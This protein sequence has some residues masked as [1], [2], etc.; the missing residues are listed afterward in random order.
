MKKKKYLT[1]GYL[2]SKVMDLC[3]EINTL[4]STEN[5]PQAFFEYS[6]HVSMLLVSVYE[7]GWRKGIKYD[8]YTYQEI[9][10]KYGISRQCAQ[11]SL[12]D[13][14]KRD[15]K[16]IKVIYAG[17]YRFMKA[18]G[19]TAKSMAEKIGITDMVFSRKSH[20][21]SQFTLR[22]IK[23]ILLITGMTFEE[24]F[25]ESEESENEK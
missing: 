8:G 24:C 7:H 6:P 9:A 17:L 18:N 15:C 11:Q 19:L 4:K 12:S 13:V 22:E 21:K 23:K 2:L 16:K 5:K 25:S 3:M 14:V 10:Y 20:G 1:R